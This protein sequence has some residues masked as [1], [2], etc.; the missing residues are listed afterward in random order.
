MARAKG[1]EKPR[2]GEQATRTLVRSPS[3]ARPLGAVVRVPKGKGAPYRFTTGHCTIGSGSTCDVVLNDPTVS[4]RHVELELVPEGVYVRDLESRNGTFYQDHRIE[5][6]VL[7]LGARIM[8]GATPVVLDADTD[9]LTSEAHFE[10]DSYRGL[11]GPSA[12]MRAL[13]GTLQ[14]LEGSLVSIL[15]IGD[16]G[17]G[18]ELVARALHEGSSVARGPLVTLNCGAIPRDLIA[19]ELFGHKKGAFTGALETRKGAFE[20]ADD[21]TLFLDEL[22]EL[23]LDVQPMLLRVLETGDVRPLGSDSSRHVRVRVVAATN[24]A[25]EDDVNAGRFRE[26]LYYRIAVVRLPVPPLRERREDIPALARAFAHAVGLP[27]LPRPVIEAL[28]ART[29]FGNVRELKNA[30]NAYAALGRLPEASR[31]PGSA[32]G[33]VAYGDAGDLLELALA[34]RLE[35]GRPYAELKEEVSDVFTRVYLEALLRQTRGNQTTAARIAGLD[36]TYLG[37]LLVKYGIAKT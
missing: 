22:G 2:D 34:S 1:P 16:S 9:S 24:R 20:S 6:A 23:P 35:L 19:S 29:W 4:R 37:R 18:K 8:V 25:L 26:D 30:V 10:G 17:V 27:E 15:V 33:R 28:K 3:D 21:G 14:R 36:R 32:R 12:A 13:F 5:R 7:A 31:G 11:L